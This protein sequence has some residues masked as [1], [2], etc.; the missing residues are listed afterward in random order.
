MWVCLGDNQVRLYI[1][2]MSQTYSFKL[3]L[4]GAAAVGKSST[5]ERF[6]KN[7][8]LEYQQPTIGAA[9]LTQSIELPDCIIRFEIWDTAGQE[10]YRGLAPMYYRGAAA[11]LIMYD[12]A[13][14]QSYENAKTW[15]IELQH[16]GSSN[17]IVAFVGNKI[18]LEEQREVPTAEAQIYAEEN[19]CLFFESSAKTGENV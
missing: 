5:V 19:N 7:D 11:A 3:V 14:R 6:L 1:R 2:D 13:D 18:D 16:Q 4:L 9:F 12:I 15:I 10:R 8:F 17:V